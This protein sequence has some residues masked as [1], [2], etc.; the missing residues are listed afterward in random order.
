MYFNYVFLT[1]LKYLK[2]LRIKYKYIT[3]NINLSYFYT[4]LRPLY[5]LYNI[6]IYFGFII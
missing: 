3:K 6:Y 5:I 4:T 2:L 1:D